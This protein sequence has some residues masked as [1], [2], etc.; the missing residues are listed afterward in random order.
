MFWWGSWSRNLLLYGQPW[1]QIYINIE[2]IGNC[3]NL[4]VVENYAERKLG[5]D[6]F[7]GKKCYLF[8]NMGVQG[9]WIFKNF[10]GFR[11]PCGKSWCFQ[12]LN[13]KSDNVI[14]MPCH[15]GGHSWVK[16]LGWYIYIY[17]HEEIFNAATATDAFQLIDSL[18]S[19]P[20]K[21]G[22]SGM[23]NGR[24]VLNAYDKLN[25]Q[26]LRDL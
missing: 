17:L 10:I 19:F 11:S 22:E 7:W 8:L 6:F 2:R 1:I 26:R 20:P 9:G 5:L 16:L 14:C 15:M 4:F 23:T 18:G 12:N 13:P 25:L 3:L 24:V 21:T